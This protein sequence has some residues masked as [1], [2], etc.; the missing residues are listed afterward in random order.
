MQAA[1]IQH[2]LASWRFILLFSFPPFL[3]ALFI[4]QLNAAGLF[5]VLLCGIVWFACWR[6]WLDERYFRVISEEN[7]AMAGEILHVIW[8][9]EKLK[10]HTLLHRQ[11][12]ALTLFRKTQWLTGVLWVAWLLAGLWGR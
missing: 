4:D 12:G 9:R 1:L 3:W 10:R 5:I 6:L 2:T 7:N 8:G 11:Q